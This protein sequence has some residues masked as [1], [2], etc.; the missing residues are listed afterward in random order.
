MDSIVVWLETLL[1]TVLKGT[2]LPAWI[3]A[4]VINFIKQH[5]TTDIIVALEAHIACYVCAKAKQ[6]VGPTPNPAEVAFLAMLE[7]VLGCSAC[8]PAAAAKP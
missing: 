4:F 2:G 1:E 5:L 8:P 6:L 3:V 7:Q